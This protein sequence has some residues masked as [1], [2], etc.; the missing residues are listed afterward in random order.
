MLSGTERAPWSTSFVFCLREIKKLEVH[1]LDIVHRNLFI[2][3]AVHLFPGGGAGIPGDGHL[4]IA[5]GKG[6]GDVRRGGL[7]HGIKLRDNQGL[8]DPQ[9]AEQVGHIA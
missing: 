2:P 5:D 1:T 7:G 4:D 3:G 8:R 6:P 9:A